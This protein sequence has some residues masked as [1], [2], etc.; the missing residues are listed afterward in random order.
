MTD[1]ANAYDGDVSSVYQ[2]KKKVTNVGC[3]KFLYVK[4]GST[5]E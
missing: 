4:T 1:G 5:I 2:S 3:S